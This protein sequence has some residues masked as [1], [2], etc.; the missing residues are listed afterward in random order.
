[1]TK[2]ERMLA[3]LRHTQPDKVPY[4]ISFT[5]KAAARL[6]A[7]LGQPIDWD[8]IDNSLTWLGTGAAGEWREV[9]P[10]IWEDPFGVQWDRH[11]DRDIG[12]VCNS[13]ITPE[14]LDDYR[15]PEIKDMACLADFTDERT[16]F[17]V[18]DLGFS[19]FERAWTLAGMETILMGMLDNAP[20]VNTLLDRILEFNLRVIDD[21]CRY[22]IDA[23][24]F[25]D[26]W[27]QQTG[28]IM[29]PELWREFF[30][31]RVAQMYGRVKAHGKFVAIHS[32]GKVDDVFP[33][34]IEA[35]LDLFNPFQPEVIDVFAAKQRYGRE[36]S[37]FGGISTQ[38]L[39]PFGT[40]EQVREEVKRLLDVVGNDGGLVAA[41]AHSIPG[42]ARPENIL[43]MIEVL[44]E[45]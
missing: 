19:L 10:N 1:M 32:C 35:G 33:D 17:V 41:P 20:F 42:D 43:A 16:E 36:L 44:H 45:Q 13:R 9:R 22:R 25:G 15:F 24:L 27:G 14:T 31:P 12:V 30:K 39:L 8:W 7:H 2:R 26:D 28:L 6:E 5:Q 37:F 23:M 21:A 11:V 18:V 40:P 29:G 3:T 38:R 4:Q 34:L